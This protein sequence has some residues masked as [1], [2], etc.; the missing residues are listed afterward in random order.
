MSDVRLSIVTVTYNAAGLVEDTLKSVIGQDFHDMEYIVVDGKSTDGTLDIINRYAS[1]IQTIVSEPDRG[2]FDAMNK[3][4]RMA[5]GQWVYFLNAGDLFAGNNV[6]NEIPWQDVDN[7]IAFY[8]DMI[9]VRGSKE[10]YSRSREVAFLHESM[11]AS[12]QAFFVKTAAAHEVG[13]DLHYKYAADYNMMLRLITAHGD[14]SFAH[15]PLTI[16][17]Y[18]AEEG[19]SSR[20]PNDVFG[21]VIAIRSHIRKDWLWYWDMT[22]YKIKKWLHY[23]SRH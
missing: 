10:E 15:I 6:L 18:E 23:K 16:A 11:P 22:K 5:K 4:L 9:Y 13:F 1:H 2:I 21:E 3:A 20:Y 7:K 19:F 14:A 8:G 12:H 17:K